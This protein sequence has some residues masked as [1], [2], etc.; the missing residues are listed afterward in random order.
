MATNRKFNARHGLS[1]GS[2]VVDVVDASGLVLDVG[3]LETLETQSK[4]NVVSS[5]NEVYELALNNAQVLESTGEPMG[6]EDRS[7][8]VI[9]F[10][11]ENRIFS[12]TPDIA[13]GHLSYFIWTKGGVRREISTQKTLQLPDVTGTYYIVFDEDGDLQYKETF[14]VFAEDAPVAYVYWNA[15]TQTAP[16]F[17]EERH[18]VVMDWATHRYLH[19]TRGAVIRAEDFEAYN[20]VVGGDGSSNNH[21]KF[22]IANGVLY[23]EDIRINITHD[24]TPAPGTFEQVL[25]GGA[26]VPLFYH[27]GDTGE[28]T[29]EQPGEYALKTSATTIQYNQ[30]S[31][32]VWG[33]APVDSNKFTS[34]W[35]V[36]TNNIEYPI[37]GILDQ[38]QYNNLSAATAKK[39]ADLDLTHL[40]LVEFRPLWHVIWRSRT[41]Y[42]NTPKAIL[43]RIED[44]RKDVVTPPV[45]G[46]LAGLEDDDHLQYLHVTN[47]RTGV[48][49]NISTSGKLA[50]TS[51]A[52][53]A[54]SISGG[55]V[56]SGSAGVGG[57]LS[58]DE[59]VTADLVSLRGN[60]VFATALA[61]SNSLT[62]DLNFILPSTYG[63][64]GQ[65]IITDGLGGLSFSPVSSVG[66]TSIVVSATDGDDA[67]DG[68]LLPVKTIKKACQLAANKPKPVCIFIRAGDYSELNPIIVPE[69]VSIIGDSLRA[70]VIRPLNANKDIF[71]VRDKCYITGLTFKDAVTESGAPDFT[72]R[73]IV[74]FDDPLDTTTSRTGYT[75]LSSE[76]TLI[77][78]SP[79]IQNCSILSFLGGSGVLVDGDKVKT[80]NKSPINAE[81]ERPV[82]GDVP[83][84]GKSMVANAFTML[85][86]GGTGW[87]VINDGYVQIVSCFQIFCKNGTYCQSG[88]YASITNS[89]TNFGLYALR[90]QGYS[91]NAFAFDRGYISALSIINNRQSITTIGAGRESINHYVLKFFNTG[92]TTEVTSQFKQP[93][94]V[95]SFNP[96]TDINYATDIFTVIDHG[97]INRTP[98]VYSANGNPEIT[99]LF[100]ETIYYAE[101]L[102]TSTFKL[103]EDEALSTP[104]EI[105]SG[106]YGTEH[107]LISNVEELI[108]DGVVEFHNEYQTLTLSAGT[109]TFT[110][111]QSVTG[112][113]GLTVSSGTVWS[114]DSVTRKLVVSLD[115]VLVAGALVRNQFIVGM[116]I[117]DHT[118][119][120]PVQATIS[121]VEKKSDLYTST[122]S[123]SSTIDGNQVL[124][125]ENLL[126][127]DIHFHRPS[128]VNSSSHTWEYAGSGTDYNALP[129]NGAKGIPEYEQYEDLPGRVYSSGTNELGDFKIG[130]AIVAEN[131][132]GN[133]FF[134]QTV[135]VGELTS[136]KLTISDVTINEI[137]TDIGL[138]DNEVGGPRN[139]RLSTQFAVR[140]FLNQRLGSFIGKSV[141]TNS[142]PGS[143]VQLNASGK[144]NTDLIPAIR[145]FN[146]FK[147]FGADSRLETFLDVPP[148]EVLAGDFVTESVLGEDVTYV[149]QSDNI[150]QFIVIDPTITPNFTG[151]T[152]IHGVISSA[153][154]QIDTSFGTGGL[155]T[156]V[157]N[158]TILTS[159]GSGYTPASGS[160]V[161]SDVTL[162][163]LSVSGSPSGAKA[164]ILVTDGVVILI[165]LKR[166]GSGYTI[167][168]TLS[169][170]PADIGGTGSG[171]VLTVSGTEQRLF[172][173]LIGEKRKFVASELAPDFISDANSPTKS[174]TNTQTFAKTFNAQAIPTGNVD[175]INNQI[176]ITSHGY[177][178]GDLVHYSSGVN[179]PLGGVI[180]DN[181]YYVKVIDPD[182]I[183]LYSTYDL[184]SANKIIITSSSTGTHTLTIEVVAIGKD[185]FYLPGHGYPTGAAV[186]LT[187]TTPPGGLLSG[188]Y[189]YVGSVTTNN[190]TLHSNKSA[191]VDSVNGIT[192]S[193]VDITSTGSGTTSLKSLDVRI[194]RAINTS[195]KESDNW[196]FLSGANIDA[197]NIISGIIATSRLGTETANSNTFL[198]G[199][200]TWRPVVQGVYLDTNS[201]GLSLTGSTHTSGSNTVYDG[202]V[203]VSLDNVDGTK[204]RTSGYTNI[205]T[206]AFDKSQFNVSTAGDVSVKS[207][208]IDAGTLDGQDSTYFL[209]PSNLISAIPV[210]R[211]GTGHESYANGQLLIGNST[212]ALSK[213]TL[214]TAANTVTVTNGN[215]TIT[216]GAASN[217]TTTRFTST[218]TTGTA[219]LVVAS[220]TK[221][222][223]LNADLLDDQSGTYYLDYNNFTNTPTI[224]NATITIQGGAGAGISANGSFTLNQTT[225]QTITIGVD[226]TVV[227]T[228]RTLQISTANGLTGG[229]DPLDLSANR[230]WSLGLTGQ[231]LA[232]H[233]LATNGL[234]VRTGVGTVAARTI[235]AGTGVSVTNG[236]GVSGNPTVAIGQAVAT[237]SDV[238]FNSVTI[239][240]N[241]V[242]N[243]TTTTI[244]ST[245]VTLDD[246]VLTLG[247]DTAPS[248]DD[249]KDRGIEFRWHNG[250]VAKV[251]FFGFD[252]STGRL[253]FIPDAT[254]TSEV[255]SGATG[256][257]DANALT[258]S[259]LKTPIT[260]NGVSFDGS[261]NITIS[262]ATPNALTAGDGLTSTGTF[263]GSV[264]R[265]FAVDSTV[266]RTTGAQTITGAKTFRGA[267]LLRVEAAAT[268]DAIVLAGRAGGTGSFATTFIP[269]TLT[270]NRTITIPNATGTMALTSDIGNGTLTLAV[271][272]TG[273]SGS[274]SFTANQT[275]GTT[276]TVTSNATSANTASTIVARDASGNFT[277]GTI[278]TSSLQVGASNTENFIAFRGTTGDAPGSFNHT[279]I[280]EFLYG[281]TESS[282][283]L[284]FK[285][286]DIEGAPGPDRI[287]LVGGN[288]VF[289]TYTSALSGTF[290]AIATSTLPQTQMIIRQNGRVGIKTS[291][292]GYDLE[293]AGSFAAT[294]KSFV[295]D[296]PTKPDHKLRYGSLEGPENGIYVRG[297]SKEFVIELPDYWVKLI[298][299]DSITVNLTPIGKTQTLWVKDIRDNKIYIGSK[300]SEINYFYMVLAER[301]DVDKLEVEI[302]LN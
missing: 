197:S 96:G 20:F 226:S 89:A 3:D 44:I 82:V 283:L 245:L 186:R 258:A 211:G 250:S 213:N 270:A 67:N 27:L 188:G 290:N 76:K 141:S 278:T 272:G 152:N 184:A 265:T 185:T 210:N 298:D 261:Q 199:D 105:E 9:S 218:Q 48:T 68:S 220:T 41:S 196:S 42:T 26:R 167:G 148:V 31:G 28:W 176:I 276:F 215:G 95:L 292:P 7:H 158:D 209:D 291:D 61:S 233:N 286:N 91:K 97:Y 147:V 200:Q 216:L 277:A 33:L 78:A 117:D 267:S 94:S 190:F 269:T 11:T 273:L 46:L 129:Q 53:D 153:D 144:I 244:N 65:A 170:N 207:G 127:K 75:G 128:I 126:G 274:A 287:R 187:A 236:D 195:S 146:T 70:V 281:G 154:G 247:G 164:D 249:G 275:G 84:Q 162:T 140:G 80:P 157:V 255:F 280:G 72:W 115:K 161:Y 99:G 180:S 37:I 231:A 151:I 295:I 16:L 66:T 119:P 179:P 81:M 139:D 192:N 135:T 252:R 124:D 217:F 171:L 110:K 149:L 90:G 54:L 10:T 63:I 32:G 155:V 106:S 181:Y 189:Y 264:A 4:S 114:Y 132:T 35:I 18:G 257:I 50:S 168:D 160:L 225:N 138:G 256:D 1:V 159:G 69:D 206:A 204:T 237:T 62:Q 224:G 101:V 198:R 212:G 288:I 194:I 297:R 122:F 259:K 260:I 294:T 238:T 268:Q 112:V 24:V 14:F 178:S 116:I 25:Q 301:V 120:T 191:A 103:Y 64:K 34:T 83:E 8:S 172:V 102:S 163:N 92:T 111:G 300:C 229:G 293:V 242:V 279:Y 285:G 49:A 150:S 173:D 40:P 248:V 254:N 183:E 71:R 19:E 228:T 201:N 246:P 60:D 107:R 223:N 203:K 2:P 239:T 284:L 302:P 142:I 98:V 109:Y 222:V 79:Y 131:R 123:I 175:V 137:S 208:V 232:L 15:D 133:I 93:S 169:A 57:S 13:N 74:A 47:D 143:V 263:D 118:S 121:V 271:S 243:G 43:A 296:H 17:A 23:D 21:A 156:G 205:G 182:T 5:I 113:S 177:S 88:G 85:S 39:F 86:F 38:E 30:L 227:R 87:R 289:Q 241:L 251:G 55:A 45:H 262:A 12:I 6:I 166:G 130:N 134:K 174:F 234:I 221:V 100:D 58:V 73:Y 52:V 108:V 235:T 29:R 136:L 36:A 230:S 282:E 77:T 240:N 56:I 145:T 59:T 125:F 219:P 193:V 165:D 253:T 266:L 202:D 299:P 22:D 214:A 51:T 104:V